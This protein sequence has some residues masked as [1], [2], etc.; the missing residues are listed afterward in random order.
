MYC[1]NCGTQNP[2]D[3]VFCQKCRSAMDGSDVSAQAPQKKKRPLWVEIVLIAVV[4]VASYVL[5]QYVFVPALSGSKDQSS[6][7]ST[8]TVNQPVNQTQMVQQPVV[9]QQTQPAPVQSSTIPISAKVP[10]SW[11]DV[12]IWAWSSSKGDAFDAWPGEAMQLGAD[13]LYSYDIPDWCNYVVISAW[14]GSIQSEDVLITDPNGMYIEIEED[15]GYIEQIATQWGE[16]YRLSNGGTCAVLETV[17]PVRN[18]TSVNFTVASEGYYNSTVVGEWEI[19]F[20][21]GD[22]WKKTHTFHYDGGT[23]DVLVTFDNPVT[24]DAVTAYPVQLGNYTYECSFG[25]WGA[26]CNP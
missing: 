12:R 22:A 15:N 9:T 4:C 14:N 8:S 25:L 6:K 3:A 18:C 23:Q 16:N 17:E 7:P 21:I 11:G 19:M 24:F 26:T 5:A 20:R 1:P 10:L 2:D 13:G